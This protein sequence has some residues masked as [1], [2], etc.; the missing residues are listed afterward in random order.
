MQEITSIPT[1]LIKIFANAGNPPRRYDDA[2]ALELLKYLQS[3]ARAENWRRRASICTS[4]TNIRRWT[5]GG[6]S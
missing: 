1:E 4:H 5:S 2:I 3:L 6:I